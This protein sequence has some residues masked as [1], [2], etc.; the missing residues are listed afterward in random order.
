MLRMHSTM[1]LYHTGFQEIRVPDV[2][3]GRTNADFGQ[4]FYLS[5]DREFACRWAREQKGRLPILNTYEL[6][7]SDLQVYR[8]QRE[9]AW[10]DYIFANRAGKADSMPETDVIIGPIAN[11]TLYN[12]FG[13]ITSGF[14]KRED[15]LA[16]LMLGPAYEQIVLKTQKAAEHLRFI[17]S[18]VLES[19]E[20]A[21]Y[22]EMVA[23]EE[24]EYQ[25][26]MGETL[27]KL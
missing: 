16:L 11:D 4:G 8:F 26:L 25:R 24:A 27:E 18:Q 19:S 10:F 2:H 9:L 12:T 7:L 6:D 5:C 17:S 3:Y 20:I 22:R 23:D 15:A 1:I 14:L 13:I 21:G